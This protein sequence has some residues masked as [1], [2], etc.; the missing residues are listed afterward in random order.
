MSCS[1]SFSNGRST[2]H[3]NNNS[4]QADRRFSSRLRQNLKIASRRFPPPQSLHNVDHYFLRADL[5]KGWRD[6][7]DRS[8]FP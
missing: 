4:S 5:T 3:T 6:D 1:A 2:Q 7:R 8:H